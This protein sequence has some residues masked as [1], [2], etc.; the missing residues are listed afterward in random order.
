M[1]AR[2]GVVRA[3]VTDRQGKPIPGFTFADARPITRDALDAALAWKKPIAA[4]AGKPI[5]LEF[6]LRRARLFALEVH[7]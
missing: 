2:K 4:I 7:R 5:R 6:T 3:Q 1:D